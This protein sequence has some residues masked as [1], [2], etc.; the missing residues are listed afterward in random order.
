LLE[1]LFLRERHLGTRPW[2]SY[3]PD[4]LERRGYVTPTDSGLRYVAP[5]L[6]VLLSPYFTRTHCFRVREA[7]RSPPGLLVLEFAPVSTVRR[8]EIKGV[9]MFEDSTRLLRRV[10]F[11]YVNL[12]ATVND[13]VAGGEIEFAQLPNG[14][15]ILPRWLIRAPVPVRGQL[16]DTVRRAGSAVNVWSYLPTG[17]PQTS[18]LRVTGGDLLTVRAERDSAALWHRPLSTLAL[19]VFERDSTRDTPETVVAGAQV[20]FAGSTMQV[21]SDDNGVVRFDG[22]VEGEYVIEVSTPLYSALGLRPERLRV[23]FPNANTNLAER[24]RVKTLPELVRQAC[25]LDTRRAALIGTVIRD[26]APVTRAPVRI[27]PAPAETA[28]AD[29]IGTAETRTGPD[30]RYAVCNVPMGVEFFVTVTAPDGTK[31]RRPIRMEP[32]EMVTFMDIVFP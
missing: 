7:R 14:A 27:E 18:R 23:K 24:L 30:G 29:T 12:P 19:T 21:V 26:G 8:S 32:A 17:I 28:V 25:G 31:V 4:T 16:A 9:L 1:T 3:S 5:D 11:Q 6:E 22:L 10:Q 15:W 20:G 2:S 13:T